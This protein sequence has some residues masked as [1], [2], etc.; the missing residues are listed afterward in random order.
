MKC[1][2]KAYK[3]VLSLLYSTP[4]G[5]GSYLYLTE[6]IALQDTLVKLLEIT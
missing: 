4:K 3:V 5:P 1:I 2:F 6:Y